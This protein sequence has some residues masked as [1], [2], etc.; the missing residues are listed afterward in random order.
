MSSPTQST[1][2]QFCAWLKPLP[3]NDAIVIGV[4]PLKVSNPVMFNW[5][6]T[7]PLLVL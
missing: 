5:P 1:N 3:V 7:P 4:E 6:I 2:C